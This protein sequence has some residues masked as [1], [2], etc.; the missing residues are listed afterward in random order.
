M[1]EMGGAPLDDIDLES[2]ILDAG[3]YP[4]FEVPDNFSA[5]SSEL[6]VGRMLTEQSVSSDGMDIEE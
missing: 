2:L 4:V 1:L 5:V 6:S 3:E